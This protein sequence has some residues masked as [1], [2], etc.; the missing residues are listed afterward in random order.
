VHAIVHGHVVES[1]GQ[2]VLVVLALPFGVLWLVLLVVRMWRGGRFSASLPIGWAAWVALV[3]VVFAVVRN[4]PWW[5]CS[6]L[7]PG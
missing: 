7:A 2:N 3:V 1:V 5:L 4:L 6:A